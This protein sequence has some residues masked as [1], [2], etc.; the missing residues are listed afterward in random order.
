MDDRTDQLFALLPAFLRSADAVEGAQVKSRTFPADP[1]PAQDFGPLRTLISILARETQVLGESLDDLSD[2]AFIETCAPWVVP[3]LADLLG[4]EGL[5]DIP[6]G[7]DQRTRVADALNLRSRKGTLSALEQAAAG[8]SGLACHA[9]E[10]WKRLMVTQSMRLV[11]PDMGGTVSLRNRA[12]LL[13]LTT[14]FDRTAHLAEVRRINSAGPGL[15]RGRYNLGNIG[16]HVWPLTPAALTGHVALQA[17]PALPTFRFHPL[18]CDAPLYDRPR[19]RAEGRSATEADLPLPI[20]RGLF[21]E[22]P[23]RFYGP[24]LAFEVFVNGIAVP[25]ATVRAANLGDAIAGGWHRSSFAGA[26]LIDPTLGRLVVGTD[27]AAVVTVTCHHARPDTIGGGEHDRSASLGSVESAQSIAPGTDPVAAIVAAGGQGTFVLTASSQ[28]RAAA[29]SIA[30]P[31]GGLLRLVAADR[32]APTLQLDGVLTVALGRGAQVEVNGLRVW[33]NQ[34]RITGTAEAPGRVTIRDCTL[35]PGL[36]LDASGISL[37]PGTPSLLMEAVGAGL[38]VERSI[39]GPAQIASEVEAVL[40][41]SAVD[42]GALTTPAL[43]GTAGAEGHSLRLIRCTVFGTTQTDRFVGGT[44]LE[45]AASLGLPT[46]DTLFAGGVTARFRQEGC[47]RF[48]RIGADDA[49]PRQYRCTSAVPQFLSLRLN[50]PH[51]LMLAPLP[52]AP[53]GTPA[54]AVQRGAES[55][56]EIGVWNRAA[57]PARFDNIA[58]SLRDFLRFGH[59]GGVFAEPR[60]A[61]RRSQ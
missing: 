53:L 33:R 15:A 28:Y 30:V 44:A 32:M 21:A 22:N 34:I 14:P 24:D 20:S 3:Y 42:A 43:S 13:R 19:A 18:G 51:Y 12:A 60:P 11:H 5:S 38:R 29:A 37:H 56:G 46:T 17:A 23:A 58:R 4:V 35:V 8:A 2:D 59:A 27:P 25:L 31:D 52:P 41:D 26:V 39:L 45:A 7:P 61:E 55:G 47:L 48:C 54:A 57:L 9:V 10:Y 16:L 40:I 49:G 36:A 1:R 50:D 6:G